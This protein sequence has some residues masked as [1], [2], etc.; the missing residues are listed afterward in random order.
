M[1][2]VVCR[3]CLY[4]SRDGAEATACP[5]CHEVEPRFGK[6]EI[7]APLGFRTDFRPKDFEGS[8]TWR[9]RALTPRISPDGIPEGDVSSMGRAR[10]RAGKATI[11]VVNDNGG[12]SF[13]FVKVADQ[14]GLVSADLIDEASSRAS[15]GSRLELPDKYTEPVRAVA[16]GSTSVTDAL[17][18]RLEDVPVGTN[19]DPIPP[20]GKGAWFSLAFLLRDAAARVLDV[21]E[22]ELRAGIRVAT[23][24]A[25][26]FGEIFLA[27][28]LDN[29]AGYA[30]WIGAPDNLQHVLD[31]ARTTVLD[32]YAAACGTSKT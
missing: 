6:L 4:L 7:A 2:I 15:R 20:G 31:R 13:R 25:G 29:G 19:L 9:P 16:F 24:P 1:E 10:V 18:L 3:A 28:T 27:D 22:N 12:K 30:T 11:F 23:T 17:L 8:F 21:G 32:S 26:R 14:P 5:V